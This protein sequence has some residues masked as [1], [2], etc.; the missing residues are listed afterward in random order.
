MIPTA[1]PDSAIGIA[2]PGKTIGDA[3][4]VKLRFD[5]T[6]MELAAAGKL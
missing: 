3:N 6:Y 4:N 2:V 5:P 1:V